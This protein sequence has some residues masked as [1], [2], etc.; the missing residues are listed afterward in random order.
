METFQL[1]ITHWQ[2]RNKICAGY[3]WVPNATVAFRTHNGPSDT[4]LQCLIEIEIV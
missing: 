3:Q 2:R 1:Q 4:R